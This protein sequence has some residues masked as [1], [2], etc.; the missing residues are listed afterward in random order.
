MSDDEKINAI[1]DILNRGNDVR[2][3]PKDERKVYRTE[4]MTSF[5]QAQEAVTQLRAQKILEIARA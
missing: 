2:E 1:T 4:R 3:W 5:T